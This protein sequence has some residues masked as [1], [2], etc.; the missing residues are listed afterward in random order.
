[1][2]KWLLDVLGTPVRTD[3]ESFA[4]SARNGRLTSRVLH[5]YG[6]IT[7]QQLESV[8]CLEDDAKALALVKPWLSGMKIDLDRGALRGVAEGQSSAAVRL[9]YELYLALK[10]RKFRYTSTLPERRILRDLVDA[11]LGKTLAPSPRDTAS[12]DAMVPGEDAPEDDGYFLEAP[13]KEHDHVIRW[14]RDRLETMVRRCRDASRGYFKLV[15]SEAGRRHVG[16]GAGEA[17]AKESSVPRFE[18]TASLDLTYGELIDEE[19]RAKEMTLRV[20]DPERGAA[21]LKDMQRRRRKAEAEASR[22]AHEAATLMVELWNGIEDGDEVLREEVAEKSLKKSKYE[23]GMHEK[24]LD[25]KA[26]R[27]TLERRRGAKPPKVDEEA[28]KR[29]PEK[30]R[31]APD[32]GCRWVRLR[33]AASDSLDCSKRYRIVPNSSTDRQQFLTQII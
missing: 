24:V 23:K 18:E 33:L 9:F 16:V 32:E 22:R 27:K 13:L 10:G 8:T 21:V 11:A 17:E 19:A 14:H 20:P 5:A 26:Q 1:M 12:S 29:A 25:V 15:A 4:R 2:E 7:K 28:A 30:V 3:T 31:E 6:L